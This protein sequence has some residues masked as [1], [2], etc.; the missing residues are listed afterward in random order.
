MPIIA[1]LDIHHLMR[2]NLGWVKRKR[3]LPSGGLYQNPHHQ[4]ESQQR[5]N[6]YLLFL[7]LQ[8]YFIV[9][10]SKLN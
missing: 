6:S 3:K 1:A 10:S 4:S 8:Q 9:H 7:S 5:R 2:V